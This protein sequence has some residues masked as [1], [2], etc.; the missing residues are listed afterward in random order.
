MHPNDRRDGSIKVL[1]ILVLLATNIAVALAH[2]RALPP[3]PGS[4]RDSRAG[5]GDSPKQALDRWQNSMR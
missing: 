5:F 4:A 1:L 3:P 2:H